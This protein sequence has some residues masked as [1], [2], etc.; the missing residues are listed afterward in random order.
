MP[1]LDSHLRAE[2]EEKVAYSGVS[3]S[4][5]SGMPQ[6]EFMVTERPEA[7]ALLNQALAKAALP[8]AA[9]GC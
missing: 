8:F 9:W 3:K 2:M 7:V 4:L 5:P 6:R 1:S